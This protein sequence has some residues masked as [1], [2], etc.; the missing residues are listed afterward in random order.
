MAM[1][2]LARSPA[3][4]PRPLAMLA[5][6]MLVH[7]VQAQPVSDRERACI[8]A[9]AG[10]A[11]QAA[12]AA[13]R[14]RLEGGGIPARRCLGLALAADGRPGAARAE[15][16]AAARAA[17]QAGDPGGAR[18]WAMA[19]NAAMAA[20]DPAGA[21]AALGQAIE[22]APGAGEPPALVAQLLVDRAGAAMAQR[23]AAAARA[24]LERALKLAPSDP[25]V[26]LFAA[27][28]A[29]AEGDLPRAR[30]HI[31][32]ARR[33]APADPEIEAESRLI[34]ALIADSPTARAAEPP[35]RITPY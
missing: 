34:G 18:L 22:A 16:E 1:P 21:R 2:M 26:R 17:V 4:I 5:A 23:D 25:Q 28:L 3:A 10:N 29:R 33:Q 13:A 14:W 7:P 11:G 19:G 27:K 30:D 9:I 20:G 6:A 12:E 8:A 31:S 35:G 24:D 15:F 32:A